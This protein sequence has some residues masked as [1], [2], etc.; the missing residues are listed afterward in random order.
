MIWGNWRNFS[1]ITFCSVEKVPRCVIASQAKQ[2]QCSKVEIATAPLGPRNDSN[3]VFNR[4]LGCLSLCSSVLRSSPIT[5]DESLANY[6]R[7]SLTSPAPTATNIL[8]KLNP[9]PAN[10]YIDLLNRALAEDLGPGDI[11]SQFLVDEDL[12]AKAVILAKQEGIVAGLFIL[13]D[14]A[15]LR[16]E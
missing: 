13:Q 11:T 8:M 2:S 9:P 12:C 3:D 7:P 16:I 4:A 14:L 10:T 5:K 6:L 15:N 1:W